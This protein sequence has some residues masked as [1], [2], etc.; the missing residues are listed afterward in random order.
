MS[1]KSETIMRDLLASAGVGTDGTQPWDMHVH[2]SRTYK[3]MLSEGI[4]GFGES[5]MDGWWDCERLDECFY[6]LIKG[7][8]EDQVKKDWKI[9]LH[10]AAA[11]LLNL[12]STRRAFEIGEKHYDVG[13]DLY[14]AILN[15]RLLKREP[16]A[17]SELFCGSIAVSG[18]HAVNENCSF[19]GAF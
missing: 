10:V 11:K 18:L 14:K 1:N 9:V 3:R 4:M 19:T 7:D 16:S 5:Y 13:N 6:K 15:Q 2:D 17:F 12:Q 8:L